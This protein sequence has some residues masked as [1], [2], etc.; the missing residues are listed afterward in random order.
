MSVRN[1]AATLRAGFGEGAST[2]LPSST[3]LADPS[4]VVDVSHDSGQAQC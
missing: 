2:P 1:H 3:R 4:D